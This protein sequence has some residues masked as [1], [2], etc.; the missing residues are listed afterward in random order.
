MK[1][2]QVI[3]QILRMVC[4]EVRRKLKS[5]GLGGE[6]KKGKECFHDEFM[7]VSILLVKS[8]TIPIL[9]RLGRL[10]EQIFYTNSKVVRRKSSHGGN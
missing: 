3:I 8:P 5:N 9:M 4:M 1:H 6:E 7:C 2:G 10:S